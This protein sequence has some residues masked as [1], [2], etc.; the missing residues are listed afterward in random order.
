MTLFSEVLRNCEIK[1]EPDV[2]VE[3]LV[4]Y[5]DMAESPIQSITFRKGVNII[6]AGDDLVQDEITGHGTGKTTLCR[7]LR[8]LLGETT[9]S[10]KNDRKLFEGVFIKGCVVGELH[11][12]GKK[13][14]VRRPFDESASYII[15]GGTVEE[16][17]SA[18]SKGVTKNQYIET[19]QLN[20]FCES[21]SFRGERAV[22]WGHLL[23]W[24]TRD[25][26]ARLSNIYHWRDPESES[27][28]PAFS[29]PKSDPLFLMRA[30]LDLLTPDE[31]LNEKEFT[32]LDTDI[33]KQKRKVETHRTEP[34]W[35]VQ[36]SEAELRIALKT[37]DSTLDDI[38]ELLWEK[39]NSLLDD[40]LSKISLQQQESIAESIVQLKAE[41]KITADKV[42]SLVKEIGAAEKKYKEVKSVASLLER[43]ID[44]NTKSVAHTDDPI[45]QSVEHE[46]K[47]EAD[48][49]AAYLGDLWC[50]FGRRLVKDCTHFKDLQPTS[51]GKSDTSETVPD[52]EKK[53]NETLADIH[54]F[55]QNAAKFTDDLGR[56][57]CRLEHIDAE[58]HELTTSKEKRQK[59]LGDIDRKISDAESCLSSIRRAH[60][61]VV[62]WRKKLESNTELHD[63]EETL[64]QMQSHQIALKRSLDT[65]VDSH[66]TNSQQFTEIF[67]SIVKSILKDTKYSGKVS[68]DANRELSFDI[69]LNKTVSKSVAINI[70]KTILADISSLVFCAIT[71]R[72]VFPRFLVHD[73]PREADLQIVH[74]KRIFEM[75]VLLQT[76]FEHY[77]CCPFQYILTTTT[78][79]ADIAPEYFP[80]PIF[81]ARDSDK[82]FLRCRL[83]EEYEKI[84]NAVTLVD[85]IE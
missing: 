49:N 26:E 60:D 54:C 2:W 34:Q 57:N 72:T 79:P 42:E 9:Y 12:K 67:D 56:Q 69:F 81:D 13:F 68:L 15:E 83:E 71:N 8:Y 74:Y 58:I 10:N 62:R 78:E 77:D 75:L 14:A 1:K 46:K 20:S 31:V 52:T 16:I 50:D 85:L 36:K 53:A 48:T 32:R 18:S 63:A 40:S 64:C 82:M 24:M 84:H 5:R 21:L 11:I 29:N 33:E 76:E 23:A 27:L 61:L 55:E 43:A 80:T 6:R 38:D 70:L 19:L 41:K 22:Q 7:F 66:K 17:L 28:S 39:S 59:E 3:R 25:Q 45:V 30:A 4:V 35:H 65:L 47:S 73:S 51:D 37:G 44:E